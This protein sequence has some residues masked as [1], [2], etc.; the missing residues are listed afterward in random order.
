MSNYAVHRK[1]WGN[2]QD[3]HGGVMVCIRASLN[4]CRLGFE[5]NKEVIFVNLKVWSQSIKI[6]VLYWPLER[7]KFCGYGWFQFPG[8]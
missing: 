4:A 5:T 1:D 3:P 6:G 7:A 8:N 2:G